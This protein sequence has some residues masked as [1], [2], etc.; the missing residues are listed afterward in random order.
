LIKYLGSKRLLVGALRAAASVMVPK[1][2]PVLDLFSGT[3]RVGQA[4]KAAGLQVHS[5]DLNAYAATIARCYVGADRAQVEARALELLSALAEVPPQVGHFTTTWCEEAR[6]FHPDNGARI[7]GM[8]QALEAWDLEEP[9]RSVVLTALMEAA[10]RVDSTT[11]VQMAYLKKWAP[12]ALK[13][14]E[15]RLPKLLS[16]TGVVTQLDAVD[17]A[18]QAGPVDLAYLDPP[19]NQHSYIGNYHV[20]ESLVLWD[21]P[22]VYGVARKRTDVRERKSP[23]NSKRRIHEA[24]SEVLDALD[25]RTLL[26]SFN[27]EGFIGEEAMIELL[28]PHGQ[29]ALTRFDYKRYVGA[30]IGIHNP[31]GKRVGKVSHLRNRELLFAVAPTATQAQAAVEAADHAMQA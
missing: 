7:E 19:Y 23:F 13:P 27:N 3:S 25:A 1:P 15:L 9:L 20:W 22:E 21:E 31:K 14:I 12:R 18:R 5:N 10:D 29:V 8:R 16:G 4:F 2:G 24:M 28:R 26:V 11:G 17:A 6:Y 30:Q